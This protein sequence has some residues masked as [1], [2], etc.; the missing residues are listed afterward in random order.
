MHHPVHGEPEEPRIEPHQQ[1]G[2]GNLVRVVHKVQPLLLSAKDH[3]FEKNAG[4]ITHERKIKVGQISWIWTLRISAASTWKSAYQE[5][6]LYLIRC[7]HKLEDSEGAWNLTLEQ[8]QL[9]KTDKLPILCWDT[10]HGK[11]VIFFT[12]KVDEVTHTWYTMTRCLGLIDNFQSY[13]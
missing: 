2:V 1:S 11:R 10:A 13:L 6:F 5:C 3:R 12:S 7:K 9:F 8:A 4:E